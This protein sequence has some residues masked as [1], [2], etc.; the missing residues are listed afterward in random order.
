MVRR[1]AS[2]DCRWNTVKSLIITGGRILTTAERGGQFL[3][4]EIL[5]GGENDA[6]H[7]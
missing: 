7:H 3:C 4:L 1:E 2:R 6:P 5:K